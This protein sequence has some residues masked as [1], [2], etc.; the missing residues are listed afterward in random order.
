MGVWSVITHPLREQLYTLIA[1]EWWVWFEMAEWAG[2]VGASLLI[3]P[4]IGE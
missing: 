2:V 4:C 1:E 3:A